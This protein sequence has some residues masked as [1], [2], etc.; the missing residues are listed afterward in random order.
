VYASLRFSPDPSL[1]KRSLNQVIE[2]EIFKRITVLCFKAGWTTG[3]VGLKYLKIV[4]SIIE[5]DDLLDDMTED[6]TDTQSKKKKKIKGIS[7]KFL[8]DKLFF[9]EVVSRALQ[10][11]LNCVLDSLARKNKHYML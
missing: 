4:R 7:I 9:Y 3:N 6:I 8:K 5:Q 11:I 1:T 10:Q 2:H